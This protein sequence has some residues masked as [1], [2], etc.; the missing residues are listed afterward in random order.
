MSKTT[1]FKKFKKAFRIARMANKNQKATVFELTEMINNSATDLSRR[2]ALKALSLIGGATLLPAC[3]KDDNEVEPI[4]EGPSIAI[5]GGGLAGLGAAYYL[6]KNGLNATV[7]EASSRFGGRA[8]SIENVL[9]GG[10][11]YES[12]GEFIDTS[13]AYIRDLAN[14]LGIELLDT[15]NAEESQFIDG[16]YFD[17]RAVTMAE[18][19]AAIEPFMPLFEADFNAVDE[20]FD[21]AAPLFDALNCTQYFDEKGIDGFLRKLLDLIV[22]GE[23]GLETDFVTALNFIYQLPIVDGDTVEVLGEVDERFLFKDGSVSLIK[24]LENQLS[25]QLVTGAALQ[26]VNQNADEK[27]VLS[28]DG[29]ADI[30]ADI[31]LLGIPVS[32]LRNIELN[33]SLP[34]T[35]TTYINEVGLATNSKVIVEYNAKPW[36]DL[37][38]SG[39]VY[40]DEGYQTSWDTTRMRTGASAQTFYLGGTTG[41]N[42]GNQMPMEIANQYTQSLNKIFPGLDMA[43]TN[44]V[45]IHTWVDNPFAKTSYACF[46]PGQYT[47]AIDHFYIESDDPEEQQYVF[48]GNLGFIGEHFS[49][50]YQGFMNGALQTGFL[51]TAYIINEL[52]G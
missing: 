41:A 49:D 40:S 13:H 36:R 28:F 15:A 4:N 47:A 44:N 5:I 6:K 19:V 21:T 46:K 24:A 14:E 16:F 12:G 43:Q 23:F 31:V 26:A 48:E 51:A 34:D 29:Q 33:I 9:S 32:I 8:F 3:N 20:D 30:T 50:E 1:L 2:K 45:Q 11:N 25:G 7:Y 10:L 38:Y 27:Y 37:G 35:L 17:G 52:M 18:V 22:I 39:A 42:I